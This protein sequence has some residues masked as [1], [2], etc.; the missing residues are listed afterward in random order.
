MRTDPKAISDRLPKLGGFDRARWEV[1][2]SNGG[3]RDIGPSDYNA[4]GVAWLTDD[5]VTQLLAAAGKWSPEAPAGFPAGLDPM[6]DNTGDWVHSEE[7]DRYVT[8]D[9]YHGEFFVNK[10][11]HAV[12]F[13]VINPPSPKSVVESVG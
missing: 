4:R 1:R 10:K 11:E 5:R 13:D 7:F 3:N 6:L 2:S 8:S 9:R 12:Y